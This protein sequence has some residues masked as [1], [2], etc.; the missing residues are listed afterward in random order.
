MRPDYREILDLCVEAPGHGAL[1]RIRVEQPVG[2]ELPGR[3]HGVPPF[4]RISV[5][6]GYAFEPPRGPQTAG[7]PG[8]RPFSSASLPVLPGYGIQFTNVREA[9]NEKSHRRSHAPR[10][11][12]RVITRAGTNVIKSSTKIGTP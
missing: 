5:S 2:V 11:L 6:A 1:R 10:S 9:V 7:S 8:M 3:A 4:L 12:G